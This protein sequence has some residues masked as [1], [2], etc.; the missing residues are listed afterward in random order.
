MQ[1]YLV[2]IYNCGELVDE[3]ILDKDS[4]IKIEDTYIFD[5][6]FWGSAWAE[7]DNGEI[8]VDELVTRIKVRAELRDEDYTI[9]DII[10]TY[11]NDEDDEVEIY[12][13][14]D[15]IDF[16]LIVADGQEI[17]K[18]LSAEE[19]KILKDAISP[20]LSVADETEE[21]G[22]RIIIRKIEDQ[23][24]PRHSSMLCLSLCTRVGATNAMTKLNHTAQTLYLQHLIVS[25]SLSITTNLN[26]TAQSHLITKLQNLIVSISLSITTNLNHTAQSLYLQHLPNSLA[27]NLTLIFSIF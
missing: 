6:Q 16:D 13:Y 2:Q 8:S 14:T 26:H 7:T 11:G 3:Q 24:T 12:A 25:I 18:V 15:L 21:F 4:K 17:E 1:K 27:L 20:Y 10:N 5:N 19:I 22:I 23:D 9:E